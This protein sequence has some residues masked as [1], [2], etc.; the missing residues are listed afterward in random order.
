MDIPDD[1]SVGDYPFL[2]ADIKWGAIGNLALLGVYL[3]DLGAKS[4][5]E[6]ELYFDQAKAQA[7][8]NAYKKY[9]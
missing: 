5:S 7:Y 4:R 9:I 1:A 3:A 2:P 8:V 6:G